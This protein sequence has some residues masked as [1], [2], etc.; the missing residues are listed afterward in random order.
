M[1]LEKKTKNLKTFNC[2]SDVSLN[3]FC[4]LFHFVLL[5]AP[6]VEHYT[7]EM[8]WKDPEI[9]S[10]MWSKWSRVAQIINRGAKVTNQNFW[11]WKTLLLKEEWT[12]GLQM[13]SFHKPRYWL[14]KDDL[15]AFYLW[16]FFSLFF[17]IEHSLLEVG[18]GVLNNN[19]SILT[20]KSLWLPAPLFEAGLA[21]CLE[22]A[23]VR[24]CHHCPP[25]MD[26]SRRVTWVWPFPSSLAPSVPAALS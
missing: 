3:V 9:W 5:I 21:E 10:K 23:L 6:Q 17:L 7:L 26:R 14:C 4:I 22:E 1:K 16:C 13:W 24:S 2:V 11:T 15:S 19:F 18:G 8:K 12:L 25:E 20:F